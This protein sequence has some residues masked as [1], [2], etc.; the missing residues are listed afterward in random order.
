MSNGDGQVPIWLGRL[1]RRLG[2]HDFRL[3]ESVIGFSVGE[4]MK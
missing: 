4:Q 3:V 1:L 2:F